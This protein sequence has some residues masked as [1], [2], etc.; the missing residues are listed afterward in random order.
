M[1]MGAPITVGVDGFAESPPAAHWAAREALLRDLRVRLIH[2]WNPPS[3]PAPALP[4]ED[5][6][7]YWSQRLLTDLVGELRDTHPGLRVSAELVPRETVPALLDAARDAEM[8]VLGSRGR[9]TPG[10]F[11]LGSTGRQILAHGVHPV[12]MVHADD[13]PLTADVAVGVSLRRPNEEALRFAFD[14]AARRGGVL[15]AVHAGTNRPEDEEA[16]GDEEEPG[17]EGALDAALRPWREQ[18]PGVPVAEAFTAERPALG[19]VHTAPG[20]GLL[21]LGRDETEPGPVPHLGSVIHAAVH[22]APCP[23]AVVPRG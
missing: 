4:H 21:V 2:A 17:A 3:P 12:I 7:S 6:Q 18:Y 15:R 1:R 23:V 11:L 19:V 22:H 20:S 10:G 8:L 16:A 14:A 5:D 13:K 9:G